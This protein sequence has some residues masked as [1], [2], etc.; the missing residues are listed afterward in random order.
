[1]IMQYKLLGATGLRV[2]ELCLGA[3]TFGEDWDWGANEE[4]SRAIFEAF[5]QAGG[6]FI[7]TANIYTNGTSEKILG[8]FITSDRERFVVATKYSSFLQMGDKAGNF[9]VR[10]NH[11]KNMMQSLEGSLIVVFTEPC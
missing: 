8:E 1:M 6:N 5:A 9:N 3:M 4:T 2:S 10:G 11:Y 7:D